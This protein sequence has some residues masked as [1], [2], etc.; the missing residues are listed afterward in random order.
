VVKRPKM[1]FYDS[2]LVCYLLGIRETLQL[3]THPLRGAIFEG[4]V[5][6]ELVKKR[7]N[8]GLPIN[9]FYWRDKTGHEIDVI[10]DDGKNLLP[11]EIKSGST[12]N[13]EFFKNITYWCNLSG[14]KKSVLLYA[15]KQQQKRSDGKT[16]LPWRNLVKVDL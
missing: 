16:V 12:F 8:A 10:V 1:Y 4:L 2:A 6:T 5:V 3:S 15:G 7:T 14:A 13:V 9:L 11:I